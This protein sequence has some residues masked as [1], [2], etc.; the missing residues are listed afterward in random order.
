M[1]PTLSSDLIEKV[2]NLSEAGLYQGKQLPGA[3]FQGYN[4]ALL[5]ALCSSIAQA[6][7]ELES[8]LLP[9]IPVII[10]IGMR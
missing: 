6:N 3:F 2:W 9:Q 10:G 1:F 5:P 4:L 8:I 7:F